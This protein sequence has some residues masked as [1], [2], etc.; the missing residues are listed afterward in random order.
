MPVSDHKNQ[1]EGRRA[2][3][4]KMRGKGPGVAS[5]SGSVVDRSQDK[6]TPHSL[7]G[8]FLLLW[9]LGCQEWMS[10]FFDGHKHQRCKRNI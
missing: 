6:D 1:H 5:A 7:M 9:V 4:E 2:V 8:K 10:L 3:R